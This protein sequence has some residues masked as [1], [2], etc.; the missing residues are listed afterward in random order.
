[1]DTNSND[2]THDEEF[3]ADGQFASDEA[4]AN[5]FGTDESSE[6]HFVAGS[7]GDGKTTRLVSWFRDHSG[8]GRTFIDPKGA[9]EEVS[10]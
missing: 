3:S 10:S 1:M 2:D 4:T 7:V 5:W 6:N 9:D 8:D